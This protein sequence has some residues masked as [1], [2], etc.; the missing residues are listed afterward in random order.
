MNENEFSWVGGGGWL[1]V[2][3]YVV[4]PDFNSSPVYS[5]SVICLVLFTSEIYE[6][7]IEEN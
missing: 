7:E 6:L 1:E 5:S 3:K 4:M 2:T